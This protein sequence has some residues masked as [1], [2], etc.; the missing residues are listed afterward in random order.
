MEGI[1]LVTCGALAWAA[2]FVLAGGAGDAVTPGRVLLVRAGLGRRALVACGA[3]GACSLGR[4][5][6]ARSP[7]REAAAAARRRAAQAGWHL[8]ADESMG[9]VLAGIACA[10]LALWPLSRSPLGCVVGLA[11]APVALRL[12]ASSA[13]RTRSRQLADEMPGVF[14][15]LAVAMG[16]GQTLAQAVGYVAMHE[17]GIAAG[18]FKV[19]AMRLACGSSAEEALG[20]LV[21]ELDAPGV[22]LLATALT[23]SQRTG[24]PLQSLFQSAARLVERQG[25]FERTL[26]VKTAQVRLSVRIVCVLPPGMV[27]VLSL[28]SPDFQAGLLTATGVGCVLVALLMDALALAI[29]RRLMKGVI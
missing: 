13:E 14:R 1:V 19:A 29:V 20:G 4:W 6:Q 23:I 5:F 18:H 15:T 28:I 3:L 22:G 26:A 17:R 8:S 16:S 7:W 2:G 24:S 9:A 27:A 21:R 25:E 11:A 12:W 10:S